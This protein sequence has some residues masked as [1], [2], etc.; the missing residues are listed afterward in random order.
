MN[1]RRPAFGLLCLLLGL[2]AGAS[3]A[4]ALAQDTARQVPAGREEVMLSFA[5]VVKKAPPAVV[6]IF[7]KRKVEQRAVPS[8]LDDPF[9]RRF[10]GGGP[11]DERR[12]QREQSSLRSGASVAAEGV[13]VPHAHAIQGPPKTQ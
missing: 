11:A 7:A 13:H 6:N 1:G 10:F 2:A 3:T 12:R 9:F 4:P 5:P 8:L